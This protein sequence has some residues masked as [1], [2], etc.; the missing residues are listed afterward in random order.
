MSK[1][2]WQDEIG[3][4]QIATYWNGKVAMWELENIHIMIDVQTRR[5]IF[6][7]VWYDHE[8]AEFKDE[9]LTYE[10]AVAQCEIE[11][12][13]KLYIEV[14]RRDLA[15]INLKEIM[16]QQAKDAERKDNEG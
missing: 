14:R 16:E 3:I 10:Q 2:S 4:D 12:P 8:A 6:D 15:V 13:D 7:R 9:R 11:I 5:V 1:K